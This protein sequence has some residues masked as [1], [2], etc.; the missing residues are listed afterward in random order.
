M[1]VPSRDPR[2]ANLL[3]LGDPGLQP[4]AQNL[5]IQ[6]VKNRQ[7]P[8]HRPAQSSRQVQG[9]GL[10]ER[11]DADLAFSGPIPEAQGPHDGPSNRGDRPVHGSSTRNPSFE[12]EKI[13]ETAIPSSRLLDGELCSS[14]A[15][16]NSRMAESQ[17][18]RSQPGLFTTNHGQGS[19]KI[20]KT[21][22]PHQLAGRSW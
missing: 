12:P 9:L 15:S 2:S 6:Y 19:R 14:H 1:S 5:L 21:G 3:R 16:R 7:R 10:R 18:L 20:W 22:L 4:L 11:A 17:R 8:G 13:D